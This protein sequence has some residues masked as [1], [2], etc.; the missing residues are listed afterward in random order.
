MNAWL[1]LII[2]ILGW[3]AALGLF[4][5]VKTRLTAV[6]AVPVW[7]AGVRFVGY[8]Q[9]RQC[10]ERR[11]MEL[12][13]GELFSVT[14]AVEAACAGPQLTAPF[15]GLDWSWSAIMDLTGWWI[16]WTIIVI[17]FVTTLHLWWQRDTAKTTDPGAL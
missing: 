7:L 9:E 11:S 2:A 15:H 1:T 5:N 8:V 3:S 16:G 4:P 13:E 17:A 10:Y 6:A 12:M 14:D